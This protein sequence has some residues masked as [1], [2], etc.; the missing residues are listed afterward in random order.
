MIPVGYMYKRV[1]TKPD[2]LAAETV[3]DVYSLS[4]CVSDDFA[5]YIKYWKHNGYWLF[6]S[7]EII[8]EIA[9]NENIDLLGTTLFYYEV[10]E[11]EFDKD[12][13]KWL[14]FMP[15]PVDTNV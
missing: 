8:R 7:P 1:E 14:L 5:D 13:K 11:Y 4:A 9:A 10:Y 12:S 2:W 15:D 6:N 3:F